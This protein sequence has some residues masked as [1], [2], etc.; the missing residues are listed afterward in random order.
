MVEYVAR[1]IKSM[2]SKKRGGAGGQAE[3]EGERKGK[4]DDEE[5]GRG[6]FF[7][8]L[9]FTA[10]L[11]GHLGEGLLWNCASINFSLTFFCYLLRV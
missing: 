10:R 2:D 8:D 6:N 1:A 7:C 5:F 4:K 9:Y 3:E 11:N